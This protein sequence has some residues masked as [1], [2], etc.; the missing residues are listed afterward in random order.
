MV[1]SAGQV[2]TASPQ[3]LVA[4]R[5]VLR[6]AP[7]ALSAAPTAHSAGR[8]NRKQLGFGF[9]SA[10]YETFFNS[11]APGFSVRTKCAGLPRTVSRFTPAS[12]MVSLGVRVVM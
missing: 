9:R 10:G 4:P 6:G 5:K 11:D 3:A 1:L 12:R 2:V 7:W 8:T